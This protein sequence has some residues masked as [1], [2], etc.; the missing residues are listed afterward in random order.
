[1]INK[2][3]LIKIFCTVAETLHFRDSAQRLAVSPQVVSRGIHEL[4]AALG[5]VLFQRSTRQVKLSDFGMRFLPQARQLLADSEALFS[6]SRHR[7]QEQRIAGLVR[8]AVP[9]MALMQQVLGDLWDKLADYP[10]L[11]LDWRSSLNLAD[12]V[13][14]QIDVGIRFG[15]PED[16]R[17]VIRKVGTAQDCI[18]A[19]PKLLEKIG[20]P[21]DWQSLQR[22][23]S[24]HYPLSSL[25][26][27]NTGRA[28]SWYLSNQHQFPPN[29][30]K[31]MSNNM[32]NELITVLKGQTIACLP[33][34]MCHPY[35]ASGELIELFPDMPRKQW[36]AYIYRPQRN[37]TPP[38]VKLVFDLLGD[39]LKERLVLG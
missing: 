11:M 19:A 2:L 29:R 12:V 22:H 10:D 21:A 25:L 13:D 30:A 15:T 1:M 4:E 26:N 39:I 36:T 8:V 28:W 32:Q 23:H 5:E 18:V 16:S 20:T 14:E 24:P 35:L 17:L 31:F 38:R 37:I 27:P 34:L 33:Y 7:E 3:E 9:E 6:Q